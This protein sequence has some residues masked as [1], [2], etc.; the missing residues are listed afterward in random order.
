MSA[1]L[2]WIFLTDHPIDD[3][4]I[5]YL[6]DKGRYVYDK[7]WK[8]QGDAMIDVVVILQTEF[9][10]RFQET[11]PIVSGR[12]IFKNLTNGDARHRKK[13]LVDLEVDVSPSAN[14]S[15]IVFEMGHTSYALAVWA[16]THIF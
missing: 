16:K 14:A 12:Y 10:T 11:R 13:H 6:R 1:P 5:I 7:I 9:L 4:K 15:T 3:S 2:I 8:P